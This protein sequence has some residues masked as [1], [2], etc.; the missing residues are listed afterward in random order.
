MPP[1]HEHPWN[2][3]PQEYT[4]TYTSNTAH[5]YATGTVTAIDFSNGSDSDAYMWLTADTPC[6]I[7][8]H[9]PP[10]RNPLAFVY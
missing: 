10:V 7:Q 2:T 3:E 9:Q 8:T 1:R 4:Y 6:R 5:G